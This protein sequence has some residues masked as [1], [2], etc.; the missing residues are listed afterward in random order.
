MRYIDDMLKMI[1]LDEM[2]GTDMRDNIIETTTEK[3]AETNGEIKLRRGTAGIVAAALAVTVGAGAIALGRASKTDGVA[4]GASV[5]AE[6]STLSEADAVAKR[7]FESAAAYCSCL[8]KDGREPQIIG[9]MR[10]DISNLRGYNDQDQAL[11]RPLYDED[12]NKIYTPDMPQDGELFVIIDPTRFMPTLVQ[13]RHDK[14]SE[15]GQWVDGTVYKDTRTPFATEPETLATDTACASADQPEAYA[16]YTVLSD[17]CWGI[18]NWEYPENMEWDLLPDAN[19]LLDFDKREQWADL[20]YLIEK[21]AGR[22]FS[23]QAY[24]SI[25]PGAAK[26]HFV[27]WRQDAQSLLQY[28]PAPKGTDVEFGKAPEGSEGD[29]LDVD[30]LLQSKQAAETI[31][32]FKAA[33]RANG[34]VKGVIALRSDIPQVE[35]WYKDFVSKNY[36]PV[37]FDPEKKIAAVDID[38]LV[39]YDYIDVDRGE[40]VYIR[41]SDMEG[42]NIYV[43]GRYYNVDDASVLGLMNESMPEAIN[44][45]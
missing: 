32:C 41:T 24:V 3:K 5:S 12:G 35:Q 6:E 7:A 14:D 34:F 15:V 4:P 39:E 25:Q 28:W 2:G 27:E 23:G 13:W 33:P 17:I 36:E 10:Y 11:F 38:Q 45:K 1:P 40:F 37:A 19:I 9:P 43:N 20:I 31:G 18:D 30:T 29:H 44:E 26:C 16:L 21:K 22:S 42:A 8:I